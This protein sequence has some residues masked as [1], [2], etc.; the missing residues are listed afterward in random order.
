[1]NRGLDTFRANWRRFRRLPP[2]DRALVC[3]A[4]FLMPFTMAGL[5]LIGFRRLK[6]LFNRFSS[7]PSGRRGLRE[8]PGKKQ[9][10]ARIVRAARSAELH[11]IGH[12]SCLERSLALWCL[13]RR[14]GIEAELQIGAQTG[15]KEFTAHAWV[16]WDGAVLNDS[17]DV[18]KDYVRFEPPVGSAKVNSR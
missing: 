11:G 9:L 16:E 18:R 2:Q 10:A 17:P 15:P 6:R 12:P 13:L 8:I 4:M 3:R 5:R 1:M 14:N 7:F